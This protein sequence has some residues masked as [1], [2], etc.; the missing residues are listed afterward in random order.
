[1]TYYSYVNEGINTFENVIKAF[2]LYENGGG[3]GLKK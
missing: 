3:F 1:M 2:T